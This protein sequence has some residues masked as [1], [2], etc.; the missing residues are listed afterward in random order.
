MDEA[1]LKERLRQYGSKT[2]LLINHGKNSGGNKW[3]LSPFILKASLSSAYLRSGRR[4]RLALV[5][6]HHHTYRSVYGGS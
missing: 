1:T 2:L 6:P 5:P 4:G 3:G